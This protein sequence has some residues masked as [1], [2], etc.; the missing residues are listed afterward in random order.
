MTIQKP[1]YTQLPNQ[2]IDSFMAQVSP[3]A[4]MV[5][6]VIC[7]K[8][9]G[10]HKDTES[11]SLKQITEI[12]GISKNSVLKGIQE[13]E[14][15]RLIIVNRPAGGRG[16]TN[17]YELNFEAMQAE[18]ASQITPENTEKGAQNEHLES[19]NSSPAE[20]LIDEKCS[21][22]EHFRPQKGAQDEHQTPEKGSRDEHTKESL[23]KGKE[24]KEI[25]APIGAST[26]HAI[27]SLFR[28][29]SEKMTGREYYRDGKEAKFIKLLEPRYESDPE[30]FIDLAR[31]Y[32]HMISRLNDAF[33][34]MQP[35]TPSSFYTLYN[36]IVSYK[37]PEAVL[38][39]ETQRTRS[40]WD[41]LMEN[42]GEYPEDKLKYLLQVNTITQSDYDYIMQHRHEVA[43]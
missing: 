1:N 2:F 38:V 26:F 19:E 36:R 31:K 43:V 20:P 18:S 9:I 27:D 33:W 4:V 17:T 40:V 34:N 12:S 37:P 29:G 16:V 39:K 41:V 7:R 30:G 22:H 32:Y 23:K 21:Q 5:Y 15:L 42:Y 35:F 3:Q 6:M 24:D 8:T 25:L 14:D 28:V 10:W 11:V 13:L